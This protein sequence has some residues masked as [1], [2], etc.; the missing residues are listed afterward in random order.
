MAAALDERA[1]GSLKSA[2]DARKLKDKSDEL[3]ADA[4]V[5]FV[6][7]ALAAGWSWERMGRGLSLTGAAVRKFWKA[8]RQRAGRLADA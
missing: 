6:R 5:R 8:N 2:L 7:D 3:D 4:R 1:N